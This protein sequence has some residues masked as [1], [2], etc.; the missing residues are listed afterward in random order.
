MNALLIG[1][2][3]T[4]RLRA[5]RAM[6]PYTLKHL[7]ITPDDAEAAQQLAS[8]LK[9]KNVFNNVYTLSQWNVFT[10]LPIHFTVDSDLVILDFGSNYLANIKNSH[11]NT[12]KN[13]AKFLF[14]CVMN[15]CAHRVLV[16]GILPRK[17]GLRGN[18]HDF[19]TN[20]A[21]YNSTMKWLCGSS[22]RADF[23]KIRG[24]ENIPVDDWSLDG[25]HPRNMSHYARRLSFSHDVRY[26][27]KK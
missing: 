18:T 24:F 12:I 7:D 22:A 3:F 17:R 21:V 13:I 14:S 26:P 6:N 9:V 25:I 27:R 15:I 1:H 5:S 19:D 23:K 16:L 4:R 10:D 20:R 8:S 2:S 11:A